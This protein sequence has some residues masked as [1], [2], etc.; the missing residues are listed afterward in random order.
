M[1]TLESHMQGEQEANRI[2]NVRFACKSAAGSASERSK[3]GGTFAGEKIR[4]KA[5]G[6]LCIIDG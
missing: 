5:P 4:W 1:Q 6:V 3:T 2:A